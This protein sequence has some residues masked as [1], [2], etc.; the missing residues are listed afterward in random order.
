MGLLVRPSNDGDLDE[1][2]CIYEYW[3]L[4]SCATFE[5]E[6]PTLEEM[7]RRRIEILQLG[8]PYLVAEE[9]GAVVAYAYANAYRSRVAYRFTVEDSIYVS[10]THVRRGCGEA[11]LKHLIAQCQQG[12]W[13]QMIAVI[14]DSANAASIGLHHRFGFR[15]VGTLSAVGFKFEQWVDTVLMQR[16]LAE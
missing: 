6:P 11:L 7:A 4:H 1:I 3:V 9:A 8:L 15:Q 2:T 5:L 14:G 10:T 13:R 12:P 16:E